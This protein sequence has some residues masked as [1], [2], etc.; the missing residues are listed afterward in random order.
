VT[1]PDLGLARG[2]ALI[3]VLMAVSCADAPRGLLSGTQS[4]PPEVQDACALATRRCARCHPIE[5]VMVSRGIG[6]DRWAMY[7]EQ[8]RL[9]PSSGISRAEAA[10][11]FQC[12]QFIESSGRF[13]P[14]SAGH[15]GSATPP[16]FASRVPPAC[17][18][19][20]ATPVRATDDGNQGRS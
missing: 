12:L 4:P 11:I 2:V 19:T 1:R 6:V 5:R 3:A 16:P 17:P 14:R 13:A 10:T 18:A 9:K 20:P 7:I 8:M 15:A